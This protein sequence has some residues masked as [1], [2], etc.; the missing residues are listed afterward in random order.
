MDWGGWAVFGLVATTLLTAALILAQL[1]G[2]TRLDLP[3][4]L[5][6]AFAADPDRARV[7]GFFVHLGFGQL[8]ALFHA[9]GFAS[10][11][12]AGWALGA[13]F[14]AARRA[15]NAAEFKEAIREIR[16]RKLEEEEYERNRRTPPS[17]ELTP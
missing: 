1:I 6:S 9:A 8:F 2:W 14:Q 16:E 10:F 7:A 13:L 5:G 15:D 4:M 3:L 11:D 12:R 17:R